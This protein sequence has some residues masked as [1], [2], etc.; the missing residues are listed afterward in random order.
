MLDRARAEAE[1][2][3][4]EKERERADIYVKYMEKVIEKGEEF[5]DS[6]LTRVEKLSTSKV[7]DKK[8]EQLKDRANILTSF[9]LR[10]KDEL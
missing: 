1:T 5:I 10:I 7:S 6:E 9:Q 4:N 2:R 3:T 8:K